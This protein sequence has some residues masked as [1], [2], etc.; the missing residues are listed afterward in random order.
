M[1]P[2]CVPWTF[3]HFVV[4]FVTDPTIG[5]HHA[6]MASRPQRCKVFAIKRGVM[7]GSDALPHIR[8]GVEILRP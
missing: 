7:I 2:Q 1:Q 5:N 8:P 6:L 4:D 3:G